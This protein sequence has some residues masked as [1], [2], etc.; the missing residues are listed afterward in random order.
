MK[1]HLLLIIFG[2]ISIAA[3]AQTHKVDVFCTIDFLGNVNYIG[4]SKLLPDS[5]KTA[6]LIDYRKKYNIKKGDDVLLWMTLDGWK[7]VNAFTGNVNSFT[8]LSYMLSREILL[9]EP[10][11]ILYV[12]NLKNI[13]IKK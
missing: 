3:F 2:F 7:L 5:Q 9:D 6:I 11:Y 8:Y 1:K 4:L 10:A 12:E 13:E